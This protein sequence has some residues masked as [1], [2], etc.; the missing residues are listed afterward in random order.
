MKVLV[1]GCAG[2]I[3][4]HLSLYLLKKKFHVVGFDSLNSYYSK[5]LKNQRLKILKK[6]QNFEFYKLDIS[7]KKKIETIINKLNPTLI[8]HLAA[9]PGIMY[10]YKNPFSY[11]KNNIIATK[12]LIDVIRK[13]K[14]IK[15]FIFAS[16]SS[17][18]G[19]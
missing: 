13:N 9:Q 17:V 12:N 19:K 2:F 14:K 8:Y 16:S 5:K 6:F 1:T 15:K 7:N 3:G 18:Y 10:S 11:T 4:H